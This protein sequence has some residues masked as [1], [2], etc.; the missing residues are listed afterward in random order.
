VKRPLAVVGLVPHAV[1]T[2]TLTELVPD[3]TVAV[4]CPESTTATFVAGVDPK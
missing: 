2:V 4:M 3:G 1:D